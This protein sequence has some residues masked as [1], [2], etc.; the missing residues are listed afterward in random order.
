MDIKTE[1]DE[2]YS[3]TQK[4][5]GLIDSGI[6]KFKFAHTHNGHFNHAIYDTRFEGYIKVTH[7]TPAELFEDDNTDCIKFSVLHEGKPLTGYVHLAALEPAETQIDVMERQVAEAKSKL[8]ELE[9]QLEEAKESESKNFKRWMPSLN[10]GYY[11]LTSNGD[12]H[13]SVYDGDDLDKARISIGNYFRTEQEATDYLDALKVF[14]EL[15]G[16]EGRKKF[17]PTEDNWAIG[18]V[19]NVN[20]MKIDPQLFSYSNSGI[21]HVYFETEEFTLAAI[22]TIGEERIKK[23]VLTMSNR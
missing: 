4:I 5:R 1:T 3:Q 2:F 14:E 23:A 17:Q 15:R 11:I 22:N 9:K 12:C 13:D 7:G 21:G 20:D 16:C 19:Y 10:E 8:A 18:W 6:T